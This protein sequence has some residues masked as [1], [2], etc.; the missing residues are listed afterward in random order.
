MI[1]YIMIPTFV[2]LRDGGMRP[3]KRLSFLP[4]HVVDG[5]LILFNQLFMTQYAELWAVK[6]LQGI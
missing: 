4:K 3:G 5:E 6:V 1:M 2:V